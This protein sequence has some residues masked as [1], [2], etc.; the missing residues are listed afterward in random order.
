MDQQ[1]DDCPYV[2]VWWIIPAQLYPNFPIWL[3][4]LEHYT[5]HPRSNLLW[6]QLTHISF[7]CVGCSQKMVHF[8]FLHCTG[9]VQ[10]EL[11]VK[12]YEDSSHVFPVFPQSIILAHLQ[13]LTLIFYGNW[14]GL[15]PQFFEPLVTPS[16]TSLSTSLTGSYWIPEVLLFLRR[17]EC[18]LER[19]VFRDALIPAAELEQLLDLV[20]PALREVSIPRTIMTDSMLQ[21]IAQGSLLPILHHIEC[22]VNPSVASF[23]CF[24][25]MVDSRWGGKCASDIHTALGR[26]RPSSPDVVL[27]GVDL[28]SKYDLQGRYISLD[29]I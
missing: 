16:L 11:D 13:S 5:T 9:L 12:P 25:E 20:S 18:V 1:N 26:Y 6:A 15:T 8:I 3:P 4:W 27:P 24:V 7:T 17:S 14:P 29:N 2:G 21:R 28:E 23:N 10:C 19:L 22:S